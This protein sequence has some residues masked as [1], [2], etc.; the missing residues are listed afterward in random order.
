MTESILNI[1]LHPTF[2]AYAI[3]AHN[4][5]LYSNAHIEH[6]STTSKHEIDI[7]QLSDWL[8]SLQDIWNIS[9]QKT[10][11]AL[12]ACPTTI[13]PDFEGGAISLGN[14]NS[15]TINDGQVIQKSLTEDFVFSMY[16]P[17]ALLKLLDSY[18]L[19]AK[20][21]PSSYGM[22]K[23]LVKHNTKE[24][25]LNLHITPSEG[26]FFFIKKDQP[27]YFNS[28]LYK[29]E[30]DLLYYTLLVYKALNLSVDLSPLSISGMVEK[31]SKIFKLLYNYI[32]DIEIRKDDL[33]LD[34]THSKIVQPNYL[35]NLLYIVK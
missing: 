4:E 24:Q 19:G 25:F 16:V 1:E 2:F 34:E 33:P 30:D 8:K 31:E 23:Y 13:T 26:H 9:F 14:L 29:N 21:V 6:L 12:H 27:I 20:I 28:F 35:A 11:I 7:Q 22:C 10:F 15:R 3:K 5:G 32:R 17:N 18:F